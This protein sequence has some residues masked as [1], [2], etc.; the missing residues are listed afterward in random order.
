MKKILIVYLLVLCSIYSVGLAQA[1][2]GGG[3]CGPVTY[4]GITPDRFE[5]MKQ[6]LQDYGIYVPPGE[7]GELYGNGIAAGFEWDRESKLTI[8]VTEKPFF[9]GCGTITDR[10]RQFAQVCE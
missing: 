5:C 1:Q 3:G 2:S 7:S 9:V 10:I 4:S 8:T 6:D